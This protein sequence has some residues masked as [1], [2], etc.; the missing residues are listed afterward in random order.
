MCSERVSIHFTGRPSRFASASTST[1][2]RVGLELGAEAAAHVGRDHAQL[3]LGDAEHAGEDEAR[4][5]RD[6]RGRVE[7][8]LVAAELADRAARLD[9]GAR[10]AVVHEPV[11]DRD[12]RLGKAGVDVAAADRPTRASCWCR[13]PPRRAASRPRAPPRDPRPPASGRSRRSRPRRRRRRR[14]GSGPTTTATGSPT[15]FTWPRFSGQCSGV[16]I[17]TPGG[18]QTIGSGPGEVARHVLAGEH[19]DDAV[20][21]LAPRTCRST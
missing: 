9:R 14:A 4:D 11:L 15:C 17:S 5:V 7:R 19:R 20:A 21:L 13:T 3:V 2:S 10:G 18:A 1:S 12:L 6:L 8:E 16:L